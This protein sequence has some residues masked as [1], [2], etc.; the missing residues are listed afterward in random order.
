MS[1]Y[2]LDT[3]IISKFAPG[4]HPVNDNLAGWMTA[5][6]AA[7]ELYLSAMTI[8]EIERGMRKLYRA[9]GVERA[10]LI[11]GTIQSD[12]PQPRSS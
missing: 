7:G 12:S 4:K 10:R 9:G 3:N 8:A 6:G 2:L 1:G 11:S 5:K